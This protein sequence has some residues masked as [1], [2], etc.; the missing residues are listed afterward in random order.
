MPLRMKMTRN[1]LLYVLGLATGIVLVE[2]GIVS[3]VRW[4]AKMV[5]I[6]PSASAALILA[7]FAVG[8][9]AMVLR[10]KCRK[11]ATGDP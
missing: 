3:P 5:G 4:V 9:L 8:C 7:M 11:A 6:S 10:Q 1:R 2:L